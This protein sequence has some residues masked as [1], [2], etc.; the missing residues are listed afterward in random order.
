MVNTSNGAPIL[1]TN[2]GWR[3]R[4]PEGRQPVGAVGDLAMSPEEPDEFK[5]TAPDFL[6][7]IEKVRRAR[8]TK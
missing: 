4:A 8:E 7:P 3:P 5:G 6:D 1:M 2:K